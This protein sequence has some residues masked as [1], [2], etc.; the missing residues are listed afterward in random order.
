[1]GKIVKASSHKI[2]RA[3]AEKDIDLINR[4][5]VK[6]LR[7]EDV[8]CFSVRLCDNDVDRDNER[9]TDNALK[10]LAKLFVGKTGITDHVWSAKNQTC[11]IYR[12]QIVAP[13][14]E[15]ATGEPLKMLCGSAY[16]VRNEQ[17]A[18]VIEA[19]EAGILKEVSIGC[20]VNKCTCSVCGKD[21]HW[22]GCGDHEK[23]R[24]YDGKVCHGVLDDASDAYE[25]S[26]VA[27][28]A[29]RGA[30]V[31]KSMADVGE[32]F[33][34]LMDADLTD[35]GEQTAALKQKIEM[36]MLD[37]EERQERAVLLSY[38]QNL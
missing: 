21:M 5:A 36:T 23:G 2:R 34:T 6:E 16:M 10:Q 37:A 11:R 8:F 1:M 13:D 25:F 4:F 12:T 35:Y 22:Y 30:G 32:A 3:D 7:P 14:G 17:T 20:R 28:P 33:R 9:F 26:F 29:Q 31:T 19:I 27:V 38:A 15:T 24:E 18:P